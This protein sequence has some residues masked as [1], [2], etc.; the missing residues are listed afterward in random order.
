MID[1]E[2]KKYKFRKDGIKELRGFKDIE[3]RY[4]K[5]YYP[6][7]EIIR[8]VVL[9]GGVEKKIVELK[10]GFL[11]NEQGDLILGVQAPEL[12]KEAIKNLLDFWA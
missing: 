2:G 11:L 1:V 10:V 8:T 5:K 4:I 7:F 12:F 3:D 9:F 6:G